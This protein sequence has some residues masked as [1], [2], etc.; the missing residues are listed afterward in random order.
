MSVCLAATGVQSMTFECFIQYNCRV[1]SW[2]TPALRE[3]QLWVESG[4]YHIMDLGI[5]SRSDPAD[6]GGG[7][8][9]AIAGG[10]RRKVAKPYSTG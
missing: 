7:S 10:H 6:L 9:P 3:V 8:I 5:F 2:L 1:T 4:H